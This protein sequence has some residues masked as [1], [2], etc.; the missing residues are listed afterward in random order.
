MPGPN[1]VAWIEN[2][3][4][5]DLN[6]FRKEISATGYSIVNFPKSIS[7]ANFSLVRKYILADL[8][9][10]SNIPNVNVLFNNFPYD[11]P[12]PFEYNINRILGAIGNMFPDAKGKF[13]SCGHVIDENLF[14]IND[15][16]VC[17]ICQFQVNELDTPTRSNMKFECVTPLKP[18]YVIGREEI[19]EKANQL[20]SRHSSLS[21]LEKDFLAEYIKYTDFRNFPEKCF[22][23]TLPFI[24]KYSKNIK[25]VTSQL[26]G[27][28]D[29]LRLAYYM[30]D[31]NAD[32]SLKDNVKFSLKGADIRNFMV[33]LETLP[34]LEE[35]F[36][37]NRERWLR[38][39]EIAHPNSAKNTNKYPKLANAFNTLRNYPKGIMTFNRKAEIYT[40]CNDI[41]GLID[42][43]ASRPGEFVRRVDFIVRNLNN[44]EEKFWKEFLPKFREVAKNIS[45][46]VLFELSSHFGDR[47]NADADT[48]IFF[49]KGNQNKYFMRP[50]NRKNVDTLHAIQ[51]VESIDEVLIDRFRTGNAPGDERKVFIDRTLHGIVVPFNR[52]GDSD[53]SENILSKGSRVAFKGDVIRLYTWWKGHVDVDLSAAFYDEN[54]DFLDHVAYTRLRSNESYSIHSGDIQSAPD[55]ATEFIDID[56]KKCVEHVGNNTRYVVSN[57]ISY[58]GDP[59]DTFECYAGFMERK[60]VSSGEL[61]EPK[62][63]KT[64]VKL[65]GKTNTFMAFAFD[66]KTR[67][68]ILIDL[69]GSRRMYSN[70]ISM[71]SKVKSMA[72][73]IVNLPNK[74]PTFAK[75]L[76]LYHSANDIIVDSPEEADIIYDVTN[77]DVQVIYDILEIE[78]GT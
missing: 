57:I 6:I 77:T 20:L 18:L 16:G 32:L 59:F 4:N 73:N 42:F 39:G 19:A 3:S 29:V 33:M 5:D 60:D 13:L 76:H 45:T 71:T 40:K 31:E 9:Q 56:I 27:A 68:V 30:S 1:N 14:N 8:S 43:L 12:D 62:S 78:P 23:E 2:V 53:K 28:T 44:D 26:S 24:Y 52:R 64:K 21:E 15:F 58:R 38:F 67:E 75:V 54:W 25:Y 36:M 74:K 35:D 47:N 7:K 11:T 41:T 49:I 17:P 22:K 72:K 37:R 61:F 63:V 34:N 10:F 50:E 70:M 65:T 66:L 55:G 51:I 69:Y 46:K 48:R